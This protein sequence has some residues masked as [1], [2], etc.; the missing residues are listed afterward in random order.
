MA[1]AD[2]KVTL[3][4]GVEVPKMAL[5]VWMI[6]DGEVAVA[7]KAAIAL[8]YRH[9]DTARAYQTIRWPGRTC[10]TRRC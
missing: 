6:P 5:G 1:I 3:S 9:V 8:G 2:E 4:N 7:V 10:S